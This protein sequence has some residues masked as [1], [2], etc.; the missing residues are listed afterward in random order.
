MTLLLT[1]LFAILS[2]VLPPCQSEDSEGCHWDAAEYGNGQGTSFVTV[3]VGAY[4]L[5]TIREDGTVST[6]VD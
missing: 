6:Y 1:L 4:L 2:S 3:R 5:V